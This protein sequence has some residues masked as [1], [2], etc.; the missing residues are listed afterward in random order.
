[1]ESMDDAS[2]ADITWTMLTVLRG[3]R[4]RVQFYRFIWAFNWNWWLDA[5]Y[6]VHDFVNVHIRST[7]AEIEARKQAVAEGKDVGPERT[8]LLWFMASNVPEEEELRSQLCLVFVPN[9]DTTSIFISNAL[10]HLARHPEAWQK[11]RNEVLACGEEQPTFE[12]LRSMVHLNGVMN[13]SKYD[14][15]LLPGPIG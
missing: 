9:N 10:W 13:E 15:L 11:L 4:L 5:V 14:T 8:D 6:K 2:K 1:M 3:G 7:Y 12:S